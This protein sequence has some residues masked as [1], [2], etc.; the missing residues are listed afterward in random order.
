MLGRGAYAV[1]AGG[2]E[3][4]A[5]GPAQTP[6]PRTLR[7]IVTDGWAALPAPAAQ[8]SYDFPDTMA[9]EGKTTYVFGFRNVT[10]FSEQQVQDQKGKAQICAPLLWF[11]EYQAALQNDV[12]ITVTNIG[13][14]IRPDLTDPHTLHWHGF[15]NAI[16]FY[17]GTP[18]MSVAVPIGRDLTYFY[19]P[20]DPGTYMYHCHFEDVEHVQMGMT[21][22]L[23]VRPRQN[24]SVL[25]GFNKFAYNDGDGSTGYDREY[26]L[27]L[28]EM[29]LES[30]WKGAHIQQAQWDQYFAD[31]WLIN[32]RSYPDTLAPSTGFYN[33]T[34]MRPTGV[35]VGDP[36]PWPNPRVDAPP[37]LS[38]NP[39]SSLVSCNVNE[40]VLLRF[41]NL[42]YQQH[43]MTA[44]G[45]VLD[46]VGK[47]ATLLANGA[48][49]TSMQTET[50]SI[51]PGESFDCLFT[52]PATPGT[53]VLY[54]RAYATSQNRDQ[55]G[56]GGM[57]TE[58]RVHP[59]GTVPAQTAPPA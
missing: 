19:Q 5:I 27:L 7:L 9:P 2:R 41:A 4:Q 30:H 53:Y 36:K 21:G 32:G 52:A 16:P 56:I 12:K 54:D 49:K 43:A 14:V 22:P 34:E 6:A 50:I 28:T 20:K 26:P 35:A 57:R 37:R 42:G 23:F 8:T 48:V 10:G 17:D 46:V 58:I 47:D 51:G 59:A 40:R 45:L 25:G 38:H 13:M 44:P 11:D 3:L 55:Q 31:A 18:E 1:A 29:W 15:R 39:M 33:A 24:G